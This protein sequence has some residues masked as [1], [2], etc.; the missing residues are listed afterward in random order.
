MWVSAPLH[1]RLGDRRER[2]STTQLHRLGQLH[3]QKL[4]HALDAGGPE[5][6]ETKDLGAT[7]ADR[8]R[9]ERERLEHVG[10]VANAAIE[11]DRDL[12]IDRSHDLLEGLDG[13]GAA[14]LL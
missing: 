9:A 14:V 7:D 13:R 5:R 10:A 4:E 2:R 3:V 6:A 11:H 8:R 1:V 12:A